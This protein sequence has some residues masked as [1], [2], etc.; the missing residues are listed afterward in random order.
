MFHIL[1]KRLRQAV[2]AHLALSYRYD[3]AVSFEAPKQPEFGELGTAVAFQL[4]KLL[5]KRDGIELRLS[6]L[7]STAQAAL[8]P[9]SAPEAD[10]FLFADHGVLPAL[11]KAGMAD[12][13]SACAGAGNNSVRLSASV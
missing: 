11:V 1:E 5:K 9:A 4:A 2:S 10:V 6:Y 7:D 3:G 8:K 13:A 12:E